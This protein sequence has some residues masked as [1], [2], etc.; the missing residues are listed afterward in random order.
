MPFILFYYLLFSIFTSIGVI[1]YFFSFFKESMFSLISFESLYVLLSD[2]TEVETCSGCSVN[3]CL[4][5]PLDLCS[6]VFPRFP[7]CSFF[8]SC[9][10]S[11]FYA[12][13]FL[14][15]FLIRKIMSSSVERLSFLC[16]WSTSWGADGS[17]LLT[18]LWRWAFLSAGCKLQ[19]SGFQ[20]IVLFQ[21]YNK[22][23]FCTNA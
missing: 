1:F 19:V 7:R 23:L 5:G 8:A 21:C 6:Y 4:H 12:T 18:W 16:I 10:F 17:V 3:S 15:N 22:V 9:F 2:V 11:D 13:D 20:V 14:M